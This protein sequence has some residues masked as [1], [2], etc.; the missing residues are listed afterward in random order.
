CWGATSHEDSPV[1]KPTLLSG[2]GSLVF[3]SVSMSRVADVTCALTTTGAAFC[4]GDNDTGQ[5]GDGTTTPRAT[6]GGVAGG[7]AFKSIAVAN[8]HVCAIAVSG[9]AYC[10]GTGPNGALGDPNQSVHLTPSPAAQGLVFQNIVAGS[11]YNCALTT[12][13]AAY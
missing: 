6:P 2:T 11:G 13:G 7:I 4:W 1:V 8:S 9:A 3:K 12:D 5:L 10:W